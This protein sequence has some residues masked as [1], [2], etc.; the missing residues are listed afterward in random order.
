M[1]WFPTPFK[2]AFPEN[3]ENG[4]IYIHSKKKW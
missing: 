3:D 4:K 2:Y 1:N